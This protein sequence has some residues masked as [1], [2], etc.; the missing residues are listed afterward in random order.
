MG[1]GKKIS[2]FASIFFLE[3]RIGLLLFRGGVDKD[4][5]VAL[6]SL[7]SVCLCAS[8][9]VQKINWFNGDR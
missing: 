3:R 4:V 5:D 1:G 8:R 6:F 9:A 7:S 2:N